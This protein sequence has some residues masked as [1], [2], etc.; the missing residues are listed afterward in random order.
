MKRYS[1]FRALVLSLF[2]RRGNQECKE[3]GWANTPLAFYL[4][5]DFEIESTVHVLTPRWKQRAST[6]SSARRRSTPQ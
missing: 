4:D 6:S 2:S 3:K 5:V 1:R